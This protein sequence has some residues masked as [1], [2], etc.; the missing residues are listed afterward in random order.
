MTHN[1]SRPGAGRGPISHA[2]ADSFMNLDPGLRRDDATVSDRLEAKASCSRTVASLHQLDFL[3]V[4]LRARVQRQ[5][6]A[7]QSVL[8]V[9]G[10]GGG[11][12]RDELIESR[13]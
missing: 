2:E 12:R 4:L 8:E 6:H 1:T 3:V 13:P 10:L 5:G 9:D 7:L 11:M